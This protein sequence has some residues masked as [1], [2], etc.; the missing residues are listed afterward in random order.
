MT[1]KLGALLLALVLAVPVLAQESAEPS[2]ETGAVTTADTLADLRAEAQRLTALAA[3]PEAGRAEAE[4]LLARIDS[5][6][7]TARTQE[8]A[9][10]QAYIA[11]LRNGDSPSVAREVAASAVSDGSV[12]LARLREELQADLS[13]FLETYPDAASVFRRGAVEVRGVEAF[14]GQ[15]AGLS[16]APMIRARLSQSR[17]GDGR[18]GAYHMTLPF[19]FGAPNLG[20]QSAP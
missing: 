18:A 1:R 8:I 14:G 5:L 17:P 12:E 20:G 2:T 10:L 19:G 6:T 15:P 7:E 11:A 9:R 16:G 4:A 13:A 3:V